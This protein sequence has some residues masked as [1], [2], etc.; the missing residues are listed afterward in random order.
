[1]T[2][3]RALS[4]SSYQKRV[5]LVLANRPHET[6]ERRGVRARPPDGFLGRP[7]STGAGAVGDNDAGRLRPDVYC[8]R[9]ATTRSVAALS[10]AAHAAEILCSL[11]RAARIA[12]FP[13][14]V[15]VRFAAWRSPRAFLPGVVAASSSRVSAFVSFAASPGGTA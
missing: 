7:T 11:R 10:A 13:T 1:M 5:F 15:S 2:E 14:C 4:A 3:E 9:P 8:P 6:A 12:I